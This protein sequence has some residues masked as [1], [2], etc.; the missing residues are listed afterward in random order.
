VLYELPSEIW[1]EDIASALV[2]AKRLPTEG[3]EALEDDTNYTV[4]GR[5]EQA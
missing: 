3:P 2:W 1:E 5:P 4:F